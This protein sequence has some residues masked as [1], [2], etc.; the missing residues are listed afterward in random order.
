MTQLNGTRAFSEKLTSFKLPEASVQRHHSATITQN[1]E[2]DIFQALKLKII[3]KQ[4]F[5]CSLTIASVFELR[6]LF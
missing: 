4:P 1:R 6:D 3:L 5:E 2:R